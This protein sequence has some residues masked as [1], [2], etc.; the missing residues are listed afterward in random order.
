MS[1]QVHT[2][3]PAWSRLLVASDCHIEVQSASAFQFRTQSVYVCISIFQRPSFLL[4][5]FVF[6]ARD[7]LG[8]SGS[9]CVPLIISCASVLLCP[10]GAKRRLDCERAFHRVSF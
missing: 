6:I 7:T 3:S 10:G 9:E 2:G 8:A 5:G 4:V 1:N